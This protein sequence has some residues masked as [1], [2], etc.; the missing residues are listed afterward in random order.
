MRRAAA[1]KN[2]RARTPLATVA[3]IAAAYGGE[4]DARRWNVA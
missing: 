3:E 2:R 4:E 1:E